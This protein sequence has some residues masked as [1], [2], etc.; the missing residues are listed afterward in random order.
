MLL[1]TGD[2]FRFKTFR[3]EATRHVRGTADKLKHHLEHTPMRIASLGYAIFAV[4]IIGLGVV[5]LLHRDFV[6]LWNP[7]P[8]RKLFICF[9]SLISTAAGFGLLV[10]RMTAIAVRL[11]LVTLFLCLLL[12]RLQTFFLNP[13]LE[14]LVSVSARGHAGRRLGALCLVCH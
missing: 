12:F 7:I 8:A 14:L 4:T 10:P 6:P 11:L 5:G 1:F 9:G 2:V 13:L 3:P